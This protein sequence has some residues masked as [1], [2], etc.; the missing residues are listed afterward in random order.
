M[1]ILFALFFRDAKYI[2]MAGDLG[3]VY[4]VLIF[5]SV[6]ISYRINIII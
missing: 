2:T 6:Q 4:G 5:F 1:F 3:I